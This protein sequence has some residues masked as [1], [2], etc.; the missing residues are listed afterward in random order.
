M[1]KLRFNKCLLAGFAIGCMLQNNQLVAQ[2]D[3][4]PVKKIIK[5]RYFNVNNSIQYLQLESSLKKG[6]LIT[7]QSNK[8][9]G[10]Y[11]DSGAASHLVAKLQT[12]ENG[13]AR[14][15]IPPVLKTVWDA[16][17]QHVFILKEAGEEVISDFAITKTAIKLDTSN[18]DGVRSITASVM[19]ME[20]NQWLPAKDVEMKI[21]VER[22]GGILSAGD[23]ATYTTDSTGS[24]NVEYKKDRLPG[25]IAG[26]IILVAKVEDNDLFGNLLAEKKV[27][28]G[29]ATKAD[30]TFFNQ[31]T[32]WTTRFRTPYW[33]LFMAYSIVIAVWGIM[34][35]LVF[36]LVKIKKLGISEQ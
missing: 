30:N 33:L 18:T 11:L 20:K 24:V 7:P 22:Q 12:D 23:A 34:M 17:P 2:A 27:S 13:K 1:K 3:S 8:E 36:Q 4:T 19:K 35:Y 5:L 15:F 21:G 16:S 28:W 10:L 31:R 25:D 29:T 14:A 9:Y 26:N 32:L 6:K